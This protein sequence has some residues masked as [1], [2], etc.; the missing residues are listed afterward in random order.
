L[1]DA[2]IHEGNVSPP[3]WSVAH[4]ELAEELFRQAAIAGEWLY[5]QGYRGTASSDFLVIRKHGQSQV[6]ICEINARVTGATYP[7][8]LARPFMPDGCWYM[9]NL[10]FRQALDGDQLLSLMAR[11]GVLYRRGADRGILPF[12]FNI[13]AQG[14]VIKGQFLCLGE[15]RETCSVLLSQAWSELPLDWGYDRD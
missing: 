7:A 15:N 2:S 9:R 6:I 4:P 1:S 3:P 12:N 11:A 5:A 14:K 13:D 10:K 8:V